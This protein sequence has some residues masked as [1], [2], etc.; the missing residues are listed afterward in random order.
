MSDKLASTLWRFLVTLVIQQG[1][2]YMC[3]TWTNIKKDVILLNITQQILNPSILR[4]LPS[5]VAGILNP[6]IQNS[7]THT[8]MYTSVLLL[9]VL[10]PTLQSPRKQWPASSSPSCSSLSVGP[11]PPPIS[12]WKQK[13]RK[14]VFIT[15]V[16][17]HRRLYIIKQRIVKG[18]SL[19]CC[20][21]TECKGWFITHSF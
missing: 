17:E 15:N 2:Q 5:R 12:C 9:V 1:G 6:Y 20:F 13:G 7:R 19:I 16:I 11:S 4:L 3:S 18:Q 10:H 21:W 8:H 14:K